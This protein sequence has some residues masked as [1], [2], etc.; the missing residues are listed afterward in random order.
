MEKSKKGKEFIII[1]CSGCGKTLKIPKDR[2][3]AKRKWGQQNFYHGSR[4]MKLR[5]REWDKLS[6]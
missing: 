2:Y 5:H 4:C 1:K 3:E 6:L